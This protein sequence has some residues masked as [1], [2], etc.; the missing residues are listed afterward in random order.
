MT[1]KRDK[2]A[3][4][5]RGGIQSGETGDIRPGFDPAAAPLETDAEAAGQPI[6]PDQVEM[7]LHAQNIGAADRQRNYDV[8][9]REP[10]SGATVPQTTRSPALR[11]FIGTMVVVAIAVAVASWIYS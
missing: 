4:Q 9:M 8:A 11:I 2:A 10:G 1:K 3:A 7:A 6:T 5:I